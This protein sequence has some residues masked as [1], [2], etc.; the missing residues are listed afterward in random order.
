M[1]ATEFAI[2]RNDLIEN[3]TPLRVC[4]GPRYEL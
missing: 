1:N 2:D 4:A 3:P